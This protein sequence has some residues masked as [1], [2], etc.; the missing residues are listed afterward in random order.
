MEKPNC[1]LAALA[2]LTSLVASRATPAYAGPSFDCKAA[3]ADAEKK[4][5]ASKRLSSLDQQIADAYKAALARLATDR[6]A[7]AALRNVQQG[8]IGV[9]DKQVFFG[10]S[11]EHEMKTHRDFLRGI[12]PRA[13]WLGIWETFGG[14]VII[15]KGPRGRL[16]V[17]AETMRDIISGSGS[18]RGAESSKWPDPRS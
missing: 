10:N 18:C 7:Q 12:A 3:K 8:F 1:L 11:P 13:G 16:N 6:A 5:C 14:V 17:D 2:M 9:R 4:I 15:T